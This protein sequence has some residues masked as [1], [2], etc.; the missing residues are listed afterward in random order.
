MTNNPKKINDLLRHGVKVNER[1]P[2]L[3]PSNP[4]NAF[5]LRTKAEKSGHII[6]LKALSNSNARGKM[7]WPPAALVGTKPFSTI[8]K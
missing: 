3:Q 1:I 5:Y 2:H 6:D 4:H 8:S 7:E